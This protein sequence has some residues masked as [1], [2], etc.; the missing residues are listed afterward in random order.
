VLMTSH[1]CAREIFE[2]GR[3]EIG[4]SGAGGDL[5]ESERA[6]I[7][8]LCANAAEKTWGADLLGHLDDL[9]VFHRM[10]EG[11]LPFILERLTRELN[12]RLAKLEITCELEPEATAFVLDRGSRFLRHGA[13]I[14]V[15]VFR[16][17][18]LFPIAD[19]VHSGQLHAGSQISVSVDGPDRLRFAARPAE[20]TPVAR[21]GS[22]HELLVP[23]ERA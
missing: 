5:E 12:E 11:H 9:I 21:T 14:M 1:L 2:A 6:R 15:K 4:F 8:Q 19:L 23:L 10:R 20:T 17:F 13:W 3:Q 18:I 16:R 7:Y 22:R